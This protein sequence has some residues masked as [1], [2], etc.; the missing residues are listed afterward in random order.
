MVKDPERFGVVSFDA[1]G[2]ATSIEEKPLKP[3]SPFAVTGLYFYDSTICDIA[4]KVKPSARGELEI[5]SVN[6]VYLEAGQLRVERFGRGF[7]WLDTGTHASL[8]EASSYVQTIEARQGMK[9]A[10]LEEIAWRK[11]WI[12]DA[13]MREAGQFFAKTDYGQYILGLLE[14][15]RR[16]D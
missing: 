15:P 13:R 12:D 14:S 2:K 6:Q 10:C 9:I 4:S 16:G 1:A 8:L 11:G 3:K 7:A 5:T